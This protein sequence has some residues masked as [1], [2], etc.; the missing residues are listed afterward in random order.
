MG[1]LEQDFAD[2]RTRMNERLLAEDNRV[3]KR[4]FSVDSLA[5]GEDGVLPK[6]TK[7]I[8][9]TRRIAGAAL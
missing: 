3:V 2:Y 9:G 4:I 8:A 1:K 7:E 5:Y 6:E